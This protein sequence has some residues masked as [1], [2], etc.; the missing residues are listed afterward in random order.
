MKKIDKKK[1]AEERFGVNK[2]QGYL[3]LGKKKPQKYLIW[4]EKRQLFRKHSFAHTQ[5]PFLIYF[6]LNINSV[7]SLYHTRQTCHDQV[8]SIDLEREN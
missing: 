7:L 3:K 5:I 2:Q 4:K 1:S 6:A 8:A